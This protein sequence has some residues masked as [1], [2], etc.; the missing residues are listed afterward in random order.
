MQLTFTTV[1][2]KLN[3][4]ACYSRPSEIALPGRPV[5]AQRWARRK[6]RKRRSRR[7]CMQDKTESVECRGD[8]G[9]RWLRTVSNGADCHEMGKRG[10][11]KT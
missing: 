10:A 1:A 2:L 5:P 11:R 6:R 3:F 9:I 7:R 4:S 8:D